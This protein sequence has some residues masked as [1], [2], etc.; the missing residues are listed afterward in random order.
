[1]KKIF[2]ILIIFN[3][4]CFYTLPAKTNNAAA[5]F[6]NA[7]YQSGCES[8]LFTPKIIFYTSYGNL[9]YDNSLNTD[10]LTAFSH[11]NDQPREQGVFTQGLAV[12]PVAYNNQFIG[13][14]YTLEDGGT[15]IVPGEI[16]I[17]FGYQNPKIYI[18][19]DLI[20]GSCRYNLVVRHEQIHQQINITAL[21]F[22]IPMIY[23]RVKMIIQSIPP[24]YIAPGNDINAELKKMVQRYQPQIEA[25]LIEFGDLIKLEQNKLDNWNNY[26]YEAEVCNKYELENMKNAQ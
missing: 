24:Y 8:I 9:T 19:N 12:A 5:R 3:F 22:F 4:I 21:E 13:K 20:P 23:K 2:F 1:M 6:F 17:Y 10:E 7:R 26:A 14:G 11:Q 25:L 18:A 15:C 16:A